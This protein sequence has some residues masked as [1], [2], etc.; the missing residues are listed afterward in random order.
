MTTIEEL[1]KKLQALLE[2]GEKSGTPYIF[3]PNYTVTETYTP[4]PHYH[5]ARPARRW[6]K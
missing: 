4:K 3:Q 6:K 2:R 5:A 1:N